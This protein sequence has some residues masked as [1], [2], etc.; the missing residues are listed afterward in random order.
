MP[1]HDTFDLDAAFGD[2]ERGL[3]AAARPGAAAAIHTARRRRRRTAGTV[4]AGLALVAGTFVVGQHA[5][6]D[7]GP[8]PADQPT[9]EGRLPDP[10]PFRDATLEASF[11]PWASGW[12]Y[13]DWRQPAYSGLQRLSAPPCSNDLR[14]RG[15][16]PLVARVSKNGTAVSA[17]HLSTA[18]TMWALA[19]SSDAAG[20]VFS[21]YA[22]E[23]DHCAGSERLHDRAWA[24]GAEAVTYR[25]PAADGVSGDDY[26]WIAHAGD[27]FAMAIVGS[28]HGPLPG[29][30]EARFVDALIAGVQSP[31]SG[32]PGPGN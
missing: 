13:P 17:D 31:D 22:S 10:S 28:R 3:S 12:F 11:A 16:D 29:D 1:E 18:Y 30:V 27:G 20:Q 2:L 14:V 7:R 8:A 19:T 15:G 23:V 26:L 32:G 24:G 6:G 4:A 21:T 5:L 9:Q 25:V